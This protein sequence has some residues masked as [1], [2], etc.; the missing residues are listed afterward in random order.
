MAEKPNVLFL[1][2]DQLR[3][4]SLPLYGETQIST[5]NIDRLAREGVTLSN[6]LSTCPVCN[7]DIHYVK[8]V[9]AVKGDNG[10]WKYRTQMT[11]VCKC[12]EKEVYS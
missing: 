8:H 5:P 4:A 7:S 1:F 6:A 10:A 3:A 9:K 11:G 2:A 12:N